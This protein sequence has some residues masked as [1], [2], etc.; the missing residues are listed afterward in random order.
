MAAGIGRVIA[1]GSIVPPGDKSITHRALVL[2]SLADGTS[3]IEGP[4]T[5]LDARSMA[6]ALR[7]LGAEIAPLRPGR[8]VVLRG[9]GLRGLTAPRGSL[10]CGNSGTAARFILGITAAYPFRTRITGDASLRRR[11]MRRVTTP[12][13]LM[14]ASF[15]EENGD[16]LPLVVHGG[17]LKPLEYQSPT[18]SAQVKGA[19]M[20]AGLA[21]GVS[22]AIREPVRS[23]D[24]TERMLR[25]LGARV[26][27]DDLALR[28]TPPATIP[29]F[30]LRVPGDPSSAAFLVAAALLADSGELE[31]RGVG[32]NPTRIGFLKVLERMDAAITVSP[33]GEVLGEPVGTL[34]VRPSRLRAVRVTPE[35]V[36][37]L[38]D[39]IPILAVLASRAEG[40]SVFRG[41][42]ELRVK[43]SD[44][45]GLLATNL[46]AVGA[47]AEATTDTLRVTGG[48][49]RPRGKVETARDHR[50]A[51]AFAV[52][53]TVRGADIRLSERKSVA[54]SY[55]GFFDHLAQVLHS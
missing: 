1:G 29:A 7:A 8:R 10:D 36:P 30:D 41:V 23:R 28:F 50:L 31:I 18:A 2:G 52:L 37:S 51:M 6:G 53:N 25:A 46:R 5:S 33:T 54:V 43:E 3:A 22:V 19:L 15:E 9:R 44:R 20:F 40:T 38:I 34:L 42:E 35:E 12:L 21:A 32:V 11:P 48:D 47:A 14:G 27:A 24:H 13:R 17:R 55:P 45:L 4:L 16:G 26:E 49:A 39:E